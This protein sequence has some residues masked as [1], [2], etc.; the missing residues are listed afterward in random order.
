MAHVEDRWWNEVAL[1]GGR[2]KRVKTK[3]FGK[4]MRYRVR[5]IAP[6]GSE[7][8]KS[9]PDR[10][11]KFAEAFLTEVESDK[12]RG[13]YIDPNA[14]R[15]LFRVF[16]ETWLRT[17][18]V[19]ESTRETMETK[20]KN[21]LLPFFGGRQ[22]RLIKSDTIR[23]W[24]VQMSAKY[25]AS[26]RA[27]TFAVLRAILNAAVDSQRIGSN[28]CEVKSV[29]APRPDVRKVVP[30]TLDRVVAVRCGLGVRY[31]VTVDVGAGCGLRQGEIF[32]LSVDDIDIDGGWL[33]VRRQVKKVRSRLVFGLPKNDKERR[34]PLPGEV[35]RALKL[36]M[37][38]V[39]PVLV[40]LPWEEP[41]G[42][43][44]S[45]RLVFSNSRN[46]AIGRNTFNDPHWANALRLAGVERGAD[47]DNGMHALRHF[48]ASAL[49]DAGESIRAVSEYL[50][51]GDPAFTLR[52][53]TH[54]MPGSDE[55]A[56][57][58]IDRLFSGS[59]PGDGLGGA[60]D[61]A[62]QGEG[63]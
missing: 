39:P 30:W 36:H 25:E 45:V 48:Y 38:E 44:V 35:S 26:T 57:N 40:T 63:R 8:S 3:L 41:A 62:T 59:R 6:D 10:E 16:A 4:G 17:S 56:R 20:L 14:G 53:Y 24:D 51:H 21:Q 33:H 61:D 12:L 47:R 9:F 43:P 1:P 18:Q 22:L 37:E 2:T 60:V 46:S 27:S 7:R 52:T 55:R 54:L 15:V 29:T 32:G 34:I 42:D 11:K 28:P 31:R 23:E 50:G 58:A 13:S 19:D 49:L 5:Y